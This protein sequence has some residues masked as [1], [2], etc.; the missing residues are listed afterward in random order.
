MPAPLNQTPMEFTPFPKA[1]TDLDPLD[2]ASIVAAKDRHV[3]EQL[4]RKEEIMVLR[5][6]AIWCLR[7][8]GPNAKEN[9][10]PLLMQY[11]EAIRGGLMKPFPK[12]NPTNRYRTPTGAPSFSNNFVNV[13]P[14]ELSKK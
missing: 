2:R 3:F 14:E 7:R 6:K 1:P 13:T 10:R 8:E 9:C 11:L 5:D 4:V 12:P